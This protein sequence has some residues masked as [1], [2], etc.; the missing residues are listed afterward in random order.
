MGVSTEPAPYNG[1]GPLAL[2]W[3]EAIKAIPDPVLRNLWVTQTYHEISRELRPFLGSDHASWFSFA[4]WAS[5]QAG[6]TIRGEDVPERV[7]HLLEKDEEYHRLLDRVNGS[8]FKRFESLAVRREHVATHVLALVNQLSEKI[9]GGNIKVF[10]DLAPIFSRFL[11]LFRNDAA[12]DHPKFASFISELNTVPALQGRDPILHSAFK[13]YYQARFE[14]DRKAKAELVLTGSGQ[15]GVHE[16]TSLQT[17]IENGLGVPA[18]EV[19]TWMASGIKARLPFHLHHDADAAL[20]PHL[21]PLARLVNHV[22]C[23]EATDHLM[24]LTLP[25]KALHMGQDVPIVPGRPMF[26]EELQELEHEDLVALARQ[27]DRS[28]NTTV[29]SAAHDWT[30][31]G[32]RLHYILDLFRSHHRQMNLYAECFTD[33][34]LQ[35]MRAGQ[36]PAGPL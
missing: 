29:G 32:D 24:R 3:I 33:E 26:P 5:K 27:Y 19:Q 13:K 7:R 20:E 31:L 8:L 2:E 17:D 12:P 21:G 11:E 22:W 14:P 6:R 16:Q 28:W 1:R 4:K 9:S 15:I 23:K 34:Q 18:H 36:V 30:R 25:E 10:V 35:A